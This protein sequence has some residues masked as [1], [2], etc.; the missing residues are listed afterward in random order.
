MLRDIALSG[1]SDVMQRIRSGELRV[2][3]TVQLSSDELEQRITSKAP[4][5]L[6]LP[7]SVRVEGTIEPVRL[8]ISPIEEPAAEA[9]PQE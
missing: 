2:I 6:G 8:V 4:V 7:D 9:S 5:I 1:P 3:A